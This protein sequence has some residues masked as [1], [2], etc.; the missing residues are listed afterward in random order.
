VKRLLGAMRLSVAAACLLAS[1]RSQSVH[2]TTVLAS[3]NKGGAGGG[4]FNLQ[5]LLGAPDGQVCSLGNGGFVT[6][7]FAVTITD[8]PGADFVVLENPFFSGPT[9]STFCETCFVEVSSNGVDFARFPSAYYGPPT[10]PGPFGLVNTGTYANLAG[11]CPVY[12]NGDPRDVVEA[13]GDAFD[14]AALKGDPLVLGGKVNLAA[15][16]QVRLVDAVAGVDRDSR[17]VVIE[18]PSTGS[19]DIDGITVIHHVASVT[20]SHPR[21]EL[22]IP[23]DGNLDLRISDPDGLSDLDP[24]ALRA[25]LYGIQ[26]NA[27][28]LL[29]ALVVTQVTPVGIT[30]RLGG[31][32]PVGLPLRASF[33]VKDRAA[34]RSGAT[35]VRPDR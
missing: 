17:G 32:L 19:A 13:G 18:D 23:A 5:N 16:T 10:N 30:F 9:G 29:G 1:L 14:L 25:S 35:A 26:V 28:D 20:A 24:A 33:S 15:I 27:I 6:L 11:V 3:D 12:R 31:P 22:V 34:Q 7:G 8:G 2:A 4:V 21:V